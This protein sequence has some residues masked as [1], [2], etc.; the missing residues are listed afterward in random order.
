MNPCAAMKV[1]ICLFTKQKTQKAKKWHDATLSWDVVANR[2]SI[3][4]EEGRV[5]E[6]MPYRKAIC[7]GDEI[8]LPSCLVQVDSEVS[9]NSLSA[10]VPVDQKPVVAV[11]PASTARTSKHPSA[12]ATAEESREDMN[13]SLVKHR[14]VDDI[15]ALLGGSLPAA[16]YRAPVYQLD[17]IDVPQQQSAVPME[18]PESLGPPKR[19][20]LHPLH[21]RQQHITATSCAPTTADENGVSATVCADERPSRR[22]RFAAPRSV[23][24]ARVIDS[25]PATDDMQRSILA[26]A[27]H[28]MSSEAELLTCGIGFPCS[29]LWSTLASQPVAR[30]SISDHFQSL[31]QYRVAY[32]QAVMEEV[33][34]RLRDIAVELFKVITSLQASDTGVDAPTCAHGP[35]RLSVVRKDGPNKDR[36]F[37]SCV[38]PMSDRNRC[39]VFH[40]ADQLKKPSSNAP[41]ARAATRVSLDKWE[42]V[43][44]AR[45]LPI[46]SNCTVVKP[47][48][49]E[50]KDVGKGRWKLV[51]RGEDG[52]QQHQASNSHFFLKLASK[53]QSS[54]YSMDDLW[55]VSS[56]EQFEHR[57]S[58]DSLWVMNAAFHGPSSAGLL[59][60]RPVSFP[61]PTLRNN[62]HVWAIRGPNA[63][64]ELLM[65]DTLRAL[66]TRDL[67]ELLPCL[68]QGTSAPPS[69]CAAFK[70][71][72]SRREV[73]DIA[74]QFVERYHL[75]E[76]QAKVL[77]D[78]VGWFDTLDSSASFTT[79][80]LLVH[81]VFGAG[82]SH[83][84]VV[85][86]ALLNVLLEKAG[87]ISARILVSACTNVAV[88][89]ILQ[90]LI[91]EKVNFVRVGSLKKIAKSVLP[92][93]ISA[94][95]SANK[96]DELKE[97]QEMLQ[98]EDMPPDERAAVQRAI[99]DVNT[100][101][102]KAR[103]RQLKTTR[104]VGVTCAA[105]RFPILDGNTFPIVILDEASQ[106]VE[107]MSLFPLRRFSC[108][109][110]VAVGDPKQLPPQ[111]CTTS[112]GEQDG[113]GKTMFVRLAAVGVAPRLLRTQYRCHPLI[114]AMPNALFYDGELRDGVG[115][116]SRAPLL[117]HMPTMVWCDT[118]EGKEMSDSSGSFYNDAEANFVVKLVEHLL[119]QGVQNSQIGVIALYKAQVALLYQR[120][121]EVSSVS[122]AQPA[123]PDATTGTERQEP[124]PSVKRR[125]CPVQISTVDAFQGSEKDIIIVSCCRTSGLGF[126]D[127][128]SRVNVTLTRAKRHLVIVGRVAT[129]SAA[130]VWEAVI[131]HVKTIPGGLQ[132]S[133]LV[134]QSGL[135]GTLISCTGV[136]AD[137]M[138]CASD[139]TQN[140]IEGDNASDDDAFALL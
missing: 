88:D 93:V 66:A 26:P 67:P 79:P 68:L 83:L 85:L 20:R 116:D 136:A 22:P 75:N 77:H 38:A 109:R 17:R 91:A 70:L 16:Q 45:G 41:V 65:L 94:R 106:M 29:T 2:I 48:G 73:I 37:Y 121:T 57:S 120:F 81:G 87:D 46:Y 100:G 18:T 117:T 107:P 130:P 13:V 30:T 113:L 126:S 86:I 103:E 47:S 101:R 31:S 64:S 131:K 50:W 54:V 32:V 114:S 8:D 104:V 71:R 60:L 89:R 10:V 108:S 84:M 119:E 12:R 127:T 140:H 40:W 82:K 118:P 123:T 19:R 115:I 90:G 55:I 1:F 24:P 111:L 44:R 53:E 112:T 25:T 122:F 102:A 58:T 56:N 28:G 125:A 9:D 132:N 43:L 7:S 36:A 129:L 98:S 62:Q 135:F 33:N 6:S 137:S 124:E 34:F 128:P 95:K 139:D 78:A 15:L 133:A 110:L 97:L 74:V 3:V 4:D 61:A 105:S 69:A 5:V 27:P 23:A 92:F 52:H 134:S 11:F 138:E 49:N 99:D 59:D 72:I 42:S 51:S 14:P 63:S 76:D 39:Q 80:V 96:S 35:C 21:P